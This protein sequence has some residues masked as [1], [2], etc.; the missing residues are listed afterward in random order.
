[1]RKT[2]LIAA[3]CVL[4]GMGA[5]AQ[6]TVKVV[7]DALP[8]KHPDDA[9]YEMGNFNGW[10][11]NDQNFQF[12]KDASGK[13]AFVAESVPADSYE[14]KFTRGS[15]A[16]TECAADGKVIPNRVV[17]VN[18]DTTF[19]VTVAGW[20]DDF[21]KN[22]PALAASARQKRKVAPSSAR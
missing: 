5:M 8:P 4:S 10:I 14:L 18:S 22:V 12:T 9:I 20:L 13:Y 19:H 7:I 17:V 16:T 2:L 11:P 6:Y 21:G 3:L 1:M 15:A